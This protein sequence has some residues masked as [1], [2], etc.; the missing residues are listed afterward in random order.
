MFIHNSQKNSSAPI[1]A[2]EYLTASSNK[3]GR[4]PVLTSAGQNSEGSQPSHYKRG[5]WRAVRP[6]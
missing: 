4:E 1:S 5:S 3:R 2:L 6:Y